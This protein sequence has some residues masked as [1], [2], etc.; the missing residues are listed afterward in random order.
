MDKDI[1]LKLALEALDSMRIVDFSVENLVGWNKAITAIKQALVQPAP[2]QTPVG[3]WVWSWL[4]NWCLRNGIAPATQ[5]S[6][7]AMVKDARSKFE[8]YP[9]AQPASCPHGM[10]DTCCENHGNCTLSASQ[11]TTEDFSVVAAPVRPVAHC[12]AGPEY[13]QQC[14]KESLP[15]YGS[16][17]IRKLREVIQSQSEI[18]KGHENGK[19]SVNFLHSGKREF[20]NRVS[21]YVVQ[22]AAA[23]PAPEVTNLAAAIEYADARWSGVDVPIEWARHF[24]D[25]IGKPYASPPAQ[26]APVP[27]TEQQKQE[28]AENWFAEDWA[29]TKAMGMM[30]DHERSLG[31]TTG[32]TEK[33][34][35]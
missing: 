13:C 24:A 29:I 15:T 3:N 5:D 28:L 10:V 19:T 27:L 21:D 23:Q 1:A 34:Q 30:Y 22:V 8:S 35:P 7:F 17:E 11:P 6:L 16:E 14:H 25:A 32:I 2:V 20:S 12:E 9:P 31:I 18:I 4:M 26:P 33:G